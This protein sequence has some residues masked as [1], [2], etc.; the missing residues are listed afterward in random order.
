ML[1]LLIIFTSAVPLTCSNPALD[2]VSESF[3]MFEETAITV[4]SGRCCRRNKF[5]I[6]ELGEHIGN[7]VL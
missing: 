2:A 3:L 5:N 1:K 6:I 7:C 4:N